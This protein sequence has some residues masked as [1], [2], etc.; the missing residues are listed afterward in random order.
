MAETSLKILSATTAKLNTNNEQT[1]KAKQNKKKQKK[2]NKKKKKKK[3]LSTI[4]DQKYQI[5]FRGIRVRDLQIFFGHFDWR[6]IAELRI[7]ITLEYASSFIWNYVIFGVLSSFS[8]V[9]RKHRPK[10]HRAA[11]T[12]FCGQSQICSVLSCDILHL[13][14]FESWNICAEMI[15]TILFRICI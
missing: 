8:G 2:K 6:K 14:L 5:C 12:Q 4:Q 11:F 1:N 9:P 3:P 7:V 13:A 15:Y 10:Q